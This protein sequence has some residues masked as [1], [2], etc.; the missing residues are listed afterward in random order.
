LSFLPTKLIK[1]EMKVSRPGGNMRKIWIALLVIAP[2]LLAHGD[3][4]NCK[5]VSG[6]IVTNVLDESGMVNGMNFGKTTLGTVTGDLRGAIG[7]YFLSITGVGTPKVVAT[8][9]HHWVTEAG[10]TIFLENATAN[11]FQVGTLAN[12]YGVGDD[13][14]TINIIGGTGRFA[15][16]TGT[17]STTGVLDI[18]QGKVVLRY[19]GEICFEQ[20]EH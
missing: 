5:E 3:E 10:D 13:S 18:N 4:K 19:Q 20:P 12:V 2:C 9:H 8:V 17:I 6:G 16:A 1:F 15:G 7:V 11:A 14:Y